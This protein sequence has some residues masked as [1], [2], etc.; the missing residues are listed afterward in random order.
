M[1]YILTNGNQPAVIDTALMSRNYN[2]FI[3]AHP[4]W[5]DKMGYD[6][7]S[8]KKYRHETICNILGYWLCG[9]EAAD[10]KDENPA[11]QFGAFIDWK[12]ETEDII[13]LLETAGKNLN[14]PLELDKIDFSGNESTDEALN[15]IGDFLA[16]RGYALLSL[17]TQSDCHHLFVIQG[18]AHKRL[19]QIAKAAGLKFWSFS[20][21]VE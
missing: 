7:E 15:V 13:M 11:I 10:K 21:V 5:C 9:Y 14:Y 12:E 18:K 4:K 6:V 20:K 16:A 17:D 2:V 3:E 19:M 8:F 1:A